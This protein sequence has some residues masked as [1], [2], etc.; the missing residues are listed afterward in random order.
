[1]PDPFY[2][3]PGGEIL[4]GDIFEAMPS[5]YVEGRPL[6]VA[7]QVTTRDPSN[8]W[9]VHPDDGAGP[10]GGFR[11]TADQGGEGGLLVHAH[12]GRAMIL[13]HDCE[14]ENDPRTRTLA[15]VRPATDLDKR[16][17]ATLFSGEEVAGYYA[18]FPLG[19]QD[20]EPSMERSFVDFRKLT[21]VRP[22]VL[23]ASTRV[24][25]LSEQLRFAVARAFTQ[26]LFR[27]VERES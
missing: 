7:R 23:A 13:S 8:L 9:E 16:T 18:I 6:L 1:M 25:S 27:R 21:T 12:L 15:M 4:Q 2:L 26:Y 5:V 14:I 17:Q 22:A 20:E 19:A 11:W 3:P 10:A 24:A